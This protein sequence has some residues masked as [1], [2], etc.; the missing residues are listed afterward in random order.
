M[1]GG[2]PAGLAAALAMRQQ[3]LQV[4]VYDGM[5]PPIDKACGEGLMPEAVQLLASLGV[6]LHGLDTVP[7]HGIVFHNVNTIAYAPLPVGPGLGIRR[8]HLH[9]RMTDEAYAAGVELHWGISVKATPGGGFSVAGRALAADF[10]VIAD[11]QCSTLAGASGFRERDC[12]SV[13]YASRQHFACTPWSDAVEVHWGNRE[14]LYITPLAGDEVGVALITSQR[15]RRLRDALPAFPAVADRLVGVANCSTERGAVTRTRRMRHVVRGN[16]AVLGD[17]SGS[18]DAVTGEGLLSALRQ[19]VALGHA[20]AHGQPHEY[21][22]AHRRCDV[23]PQR[24]ARV[25]LLLDRYPWLER[26]T[27]AAFAAQ[28][29]I[30]RAMLRMHLGQESLLSL[31]THHGPAFC[32]ALLGANAGLPWAHHEATPHRERGL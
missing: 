12:C 4:R 23:L 18:V 1:L 19:A 13:R 27:L 5:R 21:E 9:R 24:M 11:G 16:V 15:G 10:F 22:A 29:H 2:G 6:T 14:Q 26:R 8:T 30:F 31:A 20:L 28:P 7:L 3:G 17:A 32:R 25:L